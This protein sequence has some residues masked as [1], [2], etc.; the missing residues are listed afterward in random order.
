M[1]AAAGVKAIKQAW[2]AAEQDV[3]LD[4]Y[5]KDHPELAAALAKWG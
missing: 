2:Q 1:G 5:A 3:E 4:A